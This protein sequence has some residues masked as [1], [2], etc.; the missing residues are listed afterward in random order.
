MLAEADVQE[1]QFR[2]SIREPAEQLTLVPNI[3]HPER[4]ASDVMFDDLEKFGIIVGN[5]DGDFRGG[6]IHRSGL[7]D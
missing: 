5:E 4:L 2:P 7:S 6:V 1:H 3:V